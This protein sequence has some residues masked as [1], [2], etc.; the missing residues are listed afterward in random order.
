MNFGNVKIKKRND[1]DLS[2]YMI[3]TNN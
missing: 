2:D 1:F 3:Q